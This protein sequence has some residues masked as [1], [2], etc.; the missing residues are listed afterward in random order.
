MTAIQ[1]GVVQTS[2]QPVRLARSNDPYRCQSDSGA[3]ASGGPIK[4]IRHL[5]FPW[6]VLSVAPGGSLWALS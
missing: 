4:E 6:R 2:E 5:R 3:T 1:R